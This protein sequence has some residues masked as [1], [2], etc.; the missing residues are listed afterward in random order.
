SEGALPSPSWPDALFPQANTVPSDLSASE[1]EPPAETATI[2]LPG[3]RPVTPTGLNES[4]GAFPFPSS[5]EAL[6]PHANTAPSLRSARLNV[7]PEETWR[8]SESPMT[9]TG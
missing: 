8:T 4:V 9:L 3:P 2:P 5:P 1:D 7:S 6:L